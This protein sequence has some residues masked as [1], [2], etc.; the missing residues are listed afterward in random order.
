MSTRAR[1]TEPFFTVPKAAMDAIITRV[2]G[3]NVAF[4]VS[5]LC[6]LRWLANDAGGNEAKSVEATIALI[7]YRAGVGYNTAAKALGALESIGVIIVDRRAIPG[8]KGRAPSIYTFP[9]LGGRL[10][11]RKDTL[12]APS[13]TLP[14]VGGT[15]PAGT[16]QPRAE[17]YKEIPKEQKEPNPAA[18]RA[19]G[20]S[21]GLGESN[22]TKPAAQKSQKPADPC[23]IAIARIEGADPDQLTASGAKTI[24]IALASIRKV[25]QDVTPE[26]IKRRADGYVRIMPS[27]T[28]ITAHALAKHWARCGEVG[29][30]AN[31]PADRTSRRI[32]AIEPEPEGWRDFIN[33]T[34]PG[35]LYARGGDQ[36]GAQWASIE[37]AHRRYIIEQLAKHRRTAA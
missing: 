5:V 14:T 34:A 12:P 18:L 22:H 31:G 33:E 28:R 26:E 6:A 9:V 4:C 23:F 36:E 15:F 13:G 25:S 24:A 32:G 8:T 21:D 27:G 29:L 19:P 20:A 16:H 37:A 3:A 7:A 2:E 17:R 11:I 1:A 30:G 35:T 10:S